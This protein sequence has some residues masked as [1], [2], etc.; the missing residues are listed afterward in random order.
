[1]KIRKRLSILAGDRSVLPN[2][3][4]LRRDSGRPD[5]P[6]TGRTG[7]L[8]RL[9]SNQGMAESKSDQFTFKINAHSEK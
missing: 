1:L 9:D 2:R 6:E 7:W 4:I 8:G 5:I 3:L